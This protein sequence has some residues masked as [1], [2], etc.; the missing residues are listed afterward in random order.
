MLHC[1]NAI[2]LAA[3]YLCS[4]GMAATFLQLAML[5]LFKQEYSV[6]SVDFQKYTLI[7]MLPWA[8]KPIA[9][10]LCDTYGIARPAVIVLSLGASTAALV[11][12][13]ST[14]V[15][16]AIVLAT[17]CSGGIAFV[18]II[19]EGE[20][21]HIMA[22]SATEHLKRRVVSLVWAFIFVGQLASSIL[23]GFLT[24][25]QIFVAVAA[26]LFMPVFPAIAGWLY[27]N[28]DT[29]AW[30]PGISLGVLLTAS[31][32]ALVPITLYGT[33]T[34][35]LWY[36]TTAAAVLLL[37]AFKT[38]PYKLAKANAY[39]FATS[40]LYLNVSG[41]VDY[42]YTATPHCIQGGPHFDL[43]YY[44]AAGAVVSSLF[45]T[46]AVGIFTHCFK[47]I[48]NYRHMFWITAS[49]RILAASTDIITINRWN[50]A[51]GIPDKAMF[52]M[53]DAALQSVAATFETM[54]LVLLT[55]ELAAG[56]A[57]STTYA[58][59]AGFQNFGSAVAGTYGYVLQETLQV[60]FAKSEC[61]DENMAWLVGFAHMVLPLLTIP[62]SFLLID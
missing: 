15:Q 48:T 40:V 12:S 16:T 28:R 43:R 21:A 57:E 34:I 11:L 13:T 44:V 7:I 35:K 26:L 58:L 1:R 22:M 33:A 36:V 46:M 2:G 19:T 29:H 25:Q 39:M 51:A 55:S 56:G 31:A 53:G 3:V 62:L 60:S 30:L 32:I 47:N 49:I 14:T 10:A 45:A 54:P 23:S 9:A 41:A 5:P 27:S 37:C 18:D 20:Y 8:V 50:I 42:W 6:N 4:K 61:N 38:L 24:T 52:L 59:L 17:V